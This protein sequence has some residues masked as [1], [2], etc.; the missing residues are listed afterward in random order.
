MPTMGDPNM[1]AMLGMSISSTIHQIAMP[2][3]PEKLRTLL[4][5]L[6]E[7]GEMLVA[8]GDLAGR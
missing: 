7:K 5:M 3:D 6:D 4:V 2:D 8:Q 1:T